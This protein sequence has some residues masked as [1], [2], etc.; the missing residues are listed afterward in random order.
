MIFNSTEQKIIVA[1]L[2]AIME[3]DSVIMPVET[4]F[5]DSVIESFNMSLVDLDQ[6]DEI[7]INI[8]YKLFGKFESSKK[9]AAR[10]LFKK[11]AECDGFIDPR[12]LQILMK[13]GETK[14]T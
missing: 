11:M 7:D 5:L 13:F 1:I 12:E 10:E 9:E 4:K 6:I 3:A 14:N 8:A 2:I